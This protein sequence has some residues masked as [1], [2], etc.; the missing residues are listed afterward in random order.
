MS[1]PHLEIKPTHDGPDAWGQG[2]QFDYVIEETRRALSVA[3]PRDP[4]WSF[5]AVWWLTSW[6]HTVE[7]CLAR[8][9]RGLA[10]EGEYV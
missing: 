8:L 2:R 7:N 5:T 10:R 1:R 6:N 9:E 3:R 4:R